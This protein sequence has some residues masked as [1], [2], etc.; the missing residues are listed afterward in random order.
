[1]LVHTLLYMLQDYV[2]N[3]TLLYRPLVVCSYSLSVQECLYAVCQSCDLDS[4]LAAVANNIQELEC[5]WLIPSVH[6][7]DNH[8]LV[9][10]EESKCLQSRTNHLIEHPHRASRNKLTAEQERRT[11]GINTLQN[12]KEHCMEQQACY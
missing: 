7:Y 9:G 11:A 12:K 10:S 2:T 1:M 6:H 3:S 4:L 5:D 8:L